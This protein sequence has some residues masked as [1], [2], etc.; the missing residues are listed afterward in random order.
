MISYTVW[1]VNK[2]EIPMFNLDGR[3]YTTTSILCDALQTN[4]RNLNGLR[5]N[6]PEEWESIQANNKF[7]NDRA[8]I[9]K[10]L[11]FEKERFKVMRVKPT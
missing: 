2:I 8:L 6:N 11:Y 1:K 7:L 3:L 4:K 5:L 10:H 9:L